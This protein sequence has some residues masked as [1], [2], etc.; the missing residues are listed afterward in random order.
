MLVFELLLKLLKLHFFPPFCC[1]AVA[2]R[3]QHRRLNIV[4]R[5]E[6]L[7]SQTRVSGVNAAKKAAGN[8]STSQ[9]T[10][11]SINHI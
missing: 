2:L 9:P 11:Q 5:E 6:T 10:N 8:Q 3:Q 7:S 4:S 1:D